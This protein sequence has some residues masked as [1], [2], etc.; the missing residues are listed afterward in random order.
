M[1]RM[2]QAENY[3]LDFAYYKYKTLISFKI[4]VALVNL[5]QEI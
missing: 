4:Y 2:V 3:A 5:I 1:C